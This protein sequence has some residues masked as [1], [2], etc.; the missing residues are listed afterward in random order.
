M[1]LR[2]IV[3]GLINVFINFMTFLST[4]LL[5]AIDVNYYTFITGSFPVLGGVTTF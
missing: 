3:L 1:K 4:V 2:F 5:I